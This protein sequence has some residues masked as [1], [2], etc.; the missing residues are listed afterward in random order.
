MRYLLFALGLLLLAVGLVIMP[1][2]VR[3]TLGSFGLVCMGVGIA[4][5]GRTW[6]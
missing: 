5:V 3:E 4:L 6:R 2:A 1:P